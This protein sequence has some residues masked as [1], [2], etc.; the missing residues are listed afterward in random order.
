MKIVI[1][2]GSGFIG[3]PLVRRLVG[4]ADVV[5]LS[6]KPERV[7]AGRGVEWNPG[8]GGAW[9][10]EIADADVVI[11]LAG[12]NIGAGR[13]TS[14]KK[15]RLVNSRLDSTG[16]LVRAM[17]AWPDP[18]RRFIS[19][20]AIGFYGDRGD[21]VLDEASAV[22]EGFLAQLTSDWE[23]VAHRADG[24]ARVIILRFGV[25]L[26][27]DGGALPMMTLPVRMFVG[28]RIGDGNQWVSWIER[29]DLLR[30]I[31]WTLDQPD[32]R[33]VYNVTAPAPERN[34][35]F[36]RT[37]ARVLHRPAF[38]PAPGFAL[39]IALGEMAGPLLLASQRVLPANAT[40][41]G[42][43]FLHPDLSKAL[44]HVFATVTR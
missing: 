41:Q 23:T 11:N 37:L 33:P 19:A 3:E 26:A 5:V 13:W 29:E 7:K 40:A 1:A 31:E 24:A 12:E 15:K 36:I 4:R 39:K 30:M 6:R 18:S 10:R 34:R 16:A 21:A 20:S 43:T 9:E 22:G 38:I 17:Q 25:V 8:A 42:F 2:G 35:D 44:Q 32:P 14:T 27:A 28:G